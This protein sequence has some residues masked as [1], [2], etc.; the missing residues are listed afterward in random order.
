V[1][2]LEFEDGARGGS[3]DEQAPVFVTGADPGFEEGCESVAMRAPLLVGDRL[4]AADAVR[5][6]GVDLVDVGGEGEVAVQHDTQVSDWLVGEVD[7]GGAHRKV[8]AGVEAFAGGGDG[9][10]GEEL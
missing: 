5:D 2:L 9:E 4:Q 7:P 6:L 1:D 3:G 8:D 10:V